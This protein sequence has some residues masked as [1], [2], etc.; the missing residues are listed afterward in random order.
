MSYQQRTP[1]G[2]AATSPVGSDADL[3][4]P[5]QVRPANV[6]DAGIIAEI[7]VAGWQTAYR[8]ILPLEFLAGLSVTAREVGWRHWIEADAFEETP[9]WVAQADGRVIG[10]V[11]A[12]TP[13][14]DDVPSPAAEV[15]ALYVHP[16]VQRHGAGR[17]LLKAA[18]DHARA[19]G[20]RE[21]VLWVFERNA[22]ARSFYE[23]M[24]WRPDGRRQML[25]LGGASAPEVRYRLSDAR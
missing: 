20:A 12:G 23:A 22:A 4:R 11:S 2:D 1:P 16:D 24:G 3:P 17:S 14:D 6:A 25:D 15:Y 10:F 8:H 9:V 21:L 5:V 13:R 7:T 19:R 18:V